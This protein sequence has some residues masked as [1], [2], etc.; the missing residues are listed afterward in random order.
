MIASLS[1]AV[2]LGVLTSVSPCPMATNIAA[3]SFLS[4]RMDSRRLAFL[5]A[6]A[7]ASGRAAVYAA[8]GFLVSVGVAAAPSASAFLQQN[9]APFIGPLLIVVGLV[10]VGW[11]AVPFQFGLGSQSLARKVGEYGLVGEFLLGAVF[12]LTFCPVS[13]ALFFGTLLPLA[14]AEG[15]VFSMLSVYGIAT[16]LPVACIAIPIALGLNAAGRL[17]AGIQRWQGV[18]KQTTGGV[19]VVVGVVLTVLLIF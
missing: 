2:W 12:A 8:I 19:L 1:V 4:R 3:V 5:G 18:V 17:V 14:L 10:L 15:R 11:I 9:I 6:L 16:A 13:A 7:Y